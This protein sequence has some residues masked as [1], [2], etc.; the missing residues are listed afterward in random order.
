[1]VLLIVLIVY[2]VISVSAMNYLDWDRPDNVLSAL[3]CI[4][5]LG[6]LAVIISIPKRIFQKFFG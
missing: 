3:M 2:I 5:L 4:I 6:W 1:M